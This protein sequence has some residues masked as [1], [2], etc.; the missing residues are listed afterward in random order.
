M[1]VVTAIPVTIGEIMSKFN[2]MYNGSGGRPKV[3][4]KKSIKNPNYI[5]GW[6]WLL[7]DTK[8]ANKNEGH[9]YQKRK[10]SIYGIL[11][12]CKK[13]DRVWEQDRA[14]RNYKNHGIEY[15][16]EFP[17]FGL[18]RKQ[19]PNCKEAKN[20]SSIQNTNTKPNK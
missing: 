14:M 18:Q 9:K 19:C 13:C 17:T 5:K 12:H 11:L 8:V 10:K 4:K 3:E 6:E 1:G 20:G 16:K 15:Y 7:G 2:P